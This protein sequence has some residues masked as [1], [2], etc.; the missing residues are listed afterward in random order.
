MLGFKGASGAGRPMSEAPWPRRCVQRD[1]G[2]VMRRP[3]RRSRRGGAS[4]R[5][6]GTRPDY[7]RDHASG[8]GAGWSESVPS[9][10]QDGRGGLGKG[11][12]TTPRV[13]TGTPRTCHP[14][15]VASADAGTY[16]R[17]SPQR[18]VRKP[19]IAPE[20]TGWPRGTTGGN[21][22]S[23]VWGVSPVSGLCFPGPAPT[24][25]EAERSTHWYLAAAWSIMERTGGRGSHAPSD[26]I[27]AERSLSTSL[28]PSAR[29]GCPLPG[30]VIR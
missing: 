23:G 21:P 17:G 9:S 18:Q 7:A 15:A 6:S 1:E 25:G 2:T 10:T 26:S 27:V 12:T 14:R 16:A 19:I 11:D 30:K 24:A 5:W 3:S 8:N 20:A 28:L 29:G 13:S 22:P 4:R